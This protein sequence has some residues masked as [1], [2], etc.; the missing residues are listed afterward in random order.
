MLDDASYSE[1]D[2]KDI[3]LHKIVGKKSNLLNPE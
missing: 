2:M 1:R 3:S